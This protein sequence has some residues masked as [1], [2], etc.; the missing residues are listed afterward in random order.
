LR[1]TPWP[2]TG[3]WRG[4]SGGYDEGEEP[5]MEK[6]IPVTQVMKGKEDADVDL[7]REGY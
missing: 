2:C 1:L 4:L 6:R 3:G 7:D 5:R